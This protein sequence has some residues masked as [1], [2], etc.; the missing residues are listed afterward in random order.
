MSQN[1]Q[2]AFSGDR[3]F[4]QGIFVIN[5]DGTRERRLTPD[6]GWPVWF[7]DGRRIG[8]LAVGARGHQEYREVDVRSGAVRVI[9]VPLRGTNMPFSLTSD[10]R[11]LVYSNSVHVS[12]EIWLLRPAV[13]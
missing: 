12:D 9:P 4:S 5:G 13:R 1:R 6:G 3:S 10:G 2:I 11:S 8:Y 7:P